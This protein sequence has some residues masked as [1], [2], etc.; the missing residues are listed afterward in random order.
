MYL[1]VCVCVCETV[2]AMMVTLLDSGNREVVF[3][4]CGV[5]INFMVDEENRSLMK[6]ERGVAK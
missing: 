3:I 4:A 2:D 6:R 1:C 5:L